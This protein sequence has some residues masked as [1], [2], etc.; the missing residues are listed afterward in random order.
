MTKNNTMKTK[1]KMSGWKK[2]KKRTN[3]KSSK[4]QEEDI[5]KAEK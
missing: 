4:M 5:E 3:A 2:K 1:Q